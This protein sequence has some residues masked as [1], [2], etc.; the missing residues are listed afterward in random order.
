SRKSSDI[1]AIDQVLNAAYAIATDE[2]YYV[3]IGTE[4]HL[5]AATGV[6]YFSIPVWTATANGIVRNDKDWERTENEWLEVSNKG[7]PYEMKSKDWSTMSGQ[8]IGVVRS[9]G[10]LVWEVTDTDGVFSNMV[11]YSDDFASNFSVATTE[12]E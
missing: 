1:A 12:E 2:E 10:S 7:D 11:E 9:G 3:A 8:I 5:N 4:F 6:V